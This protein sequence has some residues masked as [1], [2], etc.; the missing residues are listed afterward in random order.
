MDYKKTLALVKKQNPDMPHREAQ[1][2]ASKIHKKMIGADTQKKEAIKDG[3]INPA[4]L[5]SEAIE[6]LEARIRAT[7]VNKHNVTRIC[8]EKF[9]GGELIKEKKAPDNVNTLCYY[10]DG[11]GNRVPY[12]GY[13][14]L[15]I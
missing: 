10:Q 3:T 1:K 13:F 15:F 9:G 2:K 11:N 14:K 6:E 8:H 5:S 12:T 7:G 4:K